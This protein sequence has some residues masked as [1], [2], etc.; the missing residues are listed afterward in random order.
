MITEISLAAMKEQCANLQSVSYPFLAEI[1]QAEW[2]D[3]FKPLKEKLQTK[4]SLPRKV[5]NIIQQ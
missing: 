2:N 4:N 1:L 3:I 5:I